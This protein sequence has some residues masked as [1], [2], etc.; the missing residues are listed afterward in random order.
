MPRA[1][2]EEEREAF[3]ADVHIGVLSVGAGE[4]R[5]PM[6]MPVWYAYEP[7]GTLSFFTGTGGRRA[8]K[9]PLIERAGVL[10]LLVQQETQP[11]RY[12]AVEGTVVRHRADRRRRR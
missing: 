4:G 1:M 7:G 5:A 12:V 9:S 8:R 6:T 10:T 3:L 2:T 11:Y